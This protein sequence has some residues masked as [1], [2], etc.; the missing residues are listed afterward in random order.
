MSSVAERYGKVADA[1]TDRVV[2]VPVGAWDNPAPCEGW[3]ARDVIRHLV[4]WVPGFFQNHAGLDLG[5]MPSVDDDPAAAWQALDRSIR[6]ALA[7][8]EAATREFEGPMGPMT[9]AD[10]IDS[11][12]LGDVLVHTWDLARATGL[13]ERLDPAEVHRQYEPMEGMEE[14]MRGSGHFGPR[15]PVP[16]DA[17]EQTKLIAFTGRQP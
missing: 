17:D 2:A 5:A 13:D 15:V 9:L 4:E 16:D 6:A 11:F 14:A 12:C 7:D 10:A 1:F 3:V 8:P